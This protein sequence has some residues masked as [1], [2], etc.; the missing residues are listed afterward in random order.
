MMWEA[1]T[2]KIRQLGGQVLLGR[3]VIGCRFDSARNLWI[4]TTRDADGHAEE[5][6]GENLISSMPIRELVAQIEPGVQGNDVQVTSF[7]VTSF[8][9]TLFR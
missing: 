6:C 3:R 8:Q 2:A 9:E 1:C 7:R 5:F 4:V